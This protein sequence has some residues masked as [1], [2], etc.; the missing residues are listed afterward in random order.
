MTPVTTSEKHMSSAQEY[1]APQCEHWILG[2]IVVEE[3]GGLTHKYERAILVTFKN[4][5][6]YHAALKYMDPVF[7]GSES[8]VRG[9]LKWLDKCSRR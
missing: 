8:L 1:P 3:R 2:D 6:D 9:S 7:S 5:D 4:L